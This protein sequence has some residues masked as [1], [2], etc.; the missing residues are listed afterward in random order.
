MLESL[1]AYSS[2]LAPR[3]VIV[4]VCGEMVLDLSPRPLIARLLESELAA[5]VVVDCVARAEVK[6]RHDLASWSRFPGLIRDS[7]SNLHVR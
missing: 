7:I 3:D 6:L 4:E 5:C 1:F 2:P